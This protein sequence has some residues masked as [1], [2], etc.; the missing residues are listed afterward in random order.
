MF[1]GL[2]T[3][4]KLMRGAFEKYNVSEKLLISAPAVSLAAQFCTQQKS[5]FARELEGNQRFSFSKV[6]AGLNR[7]LSIPAKMDEKPRYFL[8]C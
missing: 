8:M 4:L 3:P 2:E 7:L 1:C 6:W 5:C